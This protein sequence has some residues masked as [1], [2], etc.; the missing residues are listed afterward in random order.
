MEFLGSLGIDAKLLMAQ[1]INFGLLLWLLR[2]FLYRPIIERI[3]KDEE[4]LAQ[5]RIQKEKLAKDREAFAKDRERTETDVKKRVQAIIKEAESMAEELKKEVRKKAEREMNEIIAQ[6][7][8]QLRSKELTL[9]ADLLSEAKTALSGNILKTI[10]ESLA[11]EERTE[12]QGIFFRR[13]I[14]SLSALDEK[15]K[16]PPAGEVILEYASALDD[17]QRNRLI[18]ALSRRF[19][20]KPAVS[21]KFNEELI[22]GFRLELAGRLIESNFS[23]IINNAANIR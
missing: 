15:I 8:A 23:D 7:K 1:A 9:K 22:S 4:E 17:E 11:P 6:K 21:E 19:G 10:R 13:L 5:A 18:R 12:L 20:K 3:E 2:K 16:L 14:E